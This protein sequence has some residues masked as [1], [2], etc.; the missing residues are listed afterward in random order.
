MLPSVSWCGSTMTSLVLGINR[1]CEM[2][3]A[4]TADRMFGGWRR[5]SWLAFL[6]FYSSIPLFTKP[7]CYSGIMMTWY[8]YPHYGYIE[9]PGTVSIG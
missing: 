3:G 1:C 4:A 2:H 9:D 8:F 5:Y 6:V 7:L